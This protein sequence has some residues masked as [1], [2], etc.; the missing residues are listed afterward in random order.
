M[1]YADDPV[2]ELKEVSGTPNQKNGKTFVQI[3]KFELRLLS[4]K[5]LNVKLENLFN[6]NKQLGKIIYDLL[7]KLLFFYGTSKSLLQHY[8]AYKADLLLSPKSSNF[9]VIIRFTGESMNNILNEN[10]EVLLEELKPA[11][12]EAIGAIAQDII[13]KVLQKTAYSD[14]FLL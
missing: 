3:K 7:E 5:K 4:V 2:L 14:I 10:W 8:S 1:F 11:F 9:V 13:N 12:E 6:G